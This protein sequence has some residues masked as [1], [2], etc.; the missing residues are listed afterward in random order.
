MALISSKGMYGLAAMY[1]LCMLKSSK[2]VQIKDISANANIPQN[3]LEQLLSQLK[4]AGL[5]NSTRGAYGGYQLA[6]DADKIS[7]K[8]IFEALEGE[9]NIADSCTKNP[10]LTLFYQ[11]KKAELEKI[12]NL[13]LEEL[14]KYQQKVSRQICYNI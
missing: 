14:I 3:Y 6:K 4:K 9:F 1:E 13:S 11:E 12:F 5:V 8:E 10:A 7:V 2:P